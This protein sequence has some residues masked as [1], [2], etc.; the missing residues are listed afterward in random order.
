MN[1]I[2]DDGSIRT[3]DARKEDEKSRRRKWRLLNK[4]KP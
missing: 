3:G 2:D 4:K 1:T